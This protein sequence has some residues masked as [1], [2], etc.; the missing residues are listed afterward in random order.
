MAI[1]F[2]FTLVSCMVLLSCKAQKPA[3][4]TA[5]VNTIKPAAERTHVYVPL[6]KGKRVAVFAN[7]T[8]MVGNTHLVDT[9][10][11]MGVNVVKVFAPEH[12]FRGTADA[13]EKVDSY[14]DKATGI[15]VVSLY[16]KKR[17]PSADDLKD[18]DVLLFDIQDVGVRFY[19]YISS[20]QDYM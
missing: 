8:S 16:G 11:K 2:M 1:K 12:G 19:T 15:Q 17:K 9:L 4:E 3:A 14:T 18:V 13:G 20:L 5:A 10:Q 7:Q 6:I